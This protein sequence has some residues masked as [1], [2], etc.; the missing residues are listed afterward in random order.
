MIKSL[1]AVAFRVVLVFGV[2]A[3]GASA[4][5]AATIAPC[6]GFATVGAWETAGSCIDS[7]TAD[8]TGDKIYTFVPGGNFGAGT[9]GTGLWLF[10]VSDVTVSPTTS[11]HSITISAPTA[12]ELVGPGTYIL[13]YTISINPSLPDYTSNFIDAAQVSMN[14]A[15]GN[16][17]DTKDLFNS[18]GT[19]IGTVTSVNGATASVGLPNEHA[20]GVNETIVLGSG[21]VLY[22]FTD[23]FTEQTV[24]EPASMALMGAGLL[25]LGALLRRKRFAK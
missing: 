17:A 14:V 25:G 19:S 7:T 5:W 1:A 10:N 18:G 2:L 9:T 24:P 11:L 15:N 8:P 16:S 12:G 3:I 23:V 6:N 21:A 20:V 22:S 4:V 13:D